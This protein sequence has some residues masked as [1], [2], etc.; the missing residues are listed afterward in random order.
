MKIF[1]STDMEGITTTTLWD[2][3]NASHSSYPLHAKQMTEEV[4]ACIH[5]AKKAGAKE[6]VVKD[7]HAGGNNIDPTRMPSGVKLLRNWSGHPYNMVDGVDKTFDAALFVG[8]HGSASREGNPMSHTMS[9]SRIAYIKLNG[10]IASEFMVFSYACAL[11]GVPTVFLSGDKVLCDDFKDL[12]PKLMTCAVKDGIG[13]LTVNYSTEDTLQNIKELTEKALKQ[14]LKDA[15]IKLPESF[16][17]EIRFKDHKH[18][19]KVSWFP[20]VKR[21]CDTVVM[22][23][24]DSYFEILR[25]L[26]WLV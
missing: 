9:S 20:G 7:A 14:D 13:A 1:I 2:E 19:E 22:F 15:L 21:I 24:S 26:S 10:V 23:Q 17:V 25:T 12:H 16:E 6:I 8:Y 5:G 4:L 3:V 18:T 11:E